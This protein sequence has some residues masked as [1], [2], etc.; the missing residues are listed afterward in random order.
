MPDQ[1]DVEEEV[2]EDGD[3][4]KKPIEPLPAVDHSQIKY[5]AVQINFYSPHAEVAS[6]TN[7]QVAKIRVDL[8]I[9]A[10]GSAI[11]APV[12]SFAHMAHVLGREIMEAVRKH[13]YQQP[14]AI[15][16]QAMPVALA[17]R[18]V[19]GIAETGSGKTVAYLLPML[20]HAIAQPEL[21]KDD[22]PIGIVLCPTRELAVQIETETYKFNK[23]LGMRSITLAGGLSKLEQFKEVKRGAEI[24]ICN[25]GRLIDVVKMKGCNLQRCTYIV[26][27]EADRMFHMGFEYQMRSIVQNIRPSRQTLLFSAT[28][29]P[30]IEKLARDI[31]QQPVRITIGEAGQA[32]ANVQQFVDVLKSEDEKWAWLSKRVD[33][34]LQKGQLLVFVKSI[35]SAEE[36]SQNFQDF[37][38]KKTEFLHG[39]LDQG[40]R[41]RILKNVRKR[42]VDVL[43]ATDVAARGLDLPSIFTVVS[44]DAARDIE[45]HT[46]RI[47]RTGRAGAEGQAYTLLT[48][49]DQNKKMAA[50]L[51]ENL[52][53]AKQVVPE[54]L[55]GLAMKYGP[56]RAAKLEGRSFLGKKKGGKSEK[57]VFGLGFDAT[58]R[59]KE[60]VQELA[61]RLDKE[62]DQLAALNRQK[63]SGNLR[64]GPGKLMAKSGFVA[65]ALSEPAPA[66]K[67]APKDDGSSDEDL[68]APGV[69]SAFGKGPKASRPPAR[70]APMPQLEIVQQRPVSQPPQA[71]Q[72][73]ASAM[74]AMSA[75]QRSLPVQQ[76]FSDGP[77]AGRRSR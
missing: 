39:D 53:Q 47:G 29:P 77:L 20:V 18:D 68:F 56:F 65:A 1:P 9:S 32:A 66:P 70:P 30:K 50:L 49:D 22:G 55:K 24:A 38:G 10:T 54:D 11:P 52:E 41:M 59:Q 2:E 36:L 19:I 75:L 3:R 76:G 73:S 72:V 12:I 60:T 25:P 34:M 44:Y 7:E 6:M 63:I 62:A 42:V 58:S 69:T 28:F 35:A 64:Q 57:S 8:R 48:N 23:Q 14:T 27:D 31:L 46:H 17:G 43:I 5:N 33:G 40:E 45:T 74:L 13:G 4:R 51:V 16:A 67:Q 37:L 15:Q 61:K 21:Q 71:Q 26:L